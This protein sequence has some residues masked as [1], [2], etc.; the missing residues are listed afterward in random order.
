[1]RL[2]HWSVIILHEL[3]G[4]T[5]GRVRRFSAGARLGGT[6]RKRHQYS[7]DVAAAQADSAAEVAEARS[8]SRYHSG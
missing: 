2:D 7:V 4:G 6:L 8:P 3:A 5:A 1:M